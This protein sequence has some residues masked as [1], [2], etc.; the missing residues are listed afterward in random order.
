MA[1]TLGLVGAQRSLGSLTWAPLLRPSLRELHQQPSTLRVSHPRPR[2]LRVCPCQDRAEDWRTL[3]GE[4]LPLVGSLQ[5]IQLWACRVACS[6]CSQAHCV[7]TFQQRSSSWHTEHLCRGCQRKR[8]SSP[9]WRCHRLW[10]RAFGL[11]YGARFGGHARCGSD[12]LHLS[13]GPGRAAVQPAGRTAFGQHLGGWIV[14]LLGQLVGRPR[15]VRCLCRWLWL[16]AYR[17][18]AGAFLRPCWT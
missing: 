2:P 17:T 15:L 11:H 12:Y 1:P 4:P 16:R 18:A 3:A 14:D 7:R 5:L 13:F 9:R 10:L 6:D 8:R